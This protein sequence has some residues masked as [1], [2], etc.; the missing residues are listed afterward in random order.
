[1]VS[2]QSWEVGIESVFVWIPVAQVRGGVASV[3]AWHIRDPGKLS[4]TVRESYSTQSQHSVRR[5]SCSL[6][7]RTRLSTTPQSAGF[8]GAVKSR[9][10]TFSLSP[11]KRQGLSRSC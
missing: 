8:L 3:T 2:E 6:R 4:P 11:L 7:N 10:A 9:R 1:M 5:K